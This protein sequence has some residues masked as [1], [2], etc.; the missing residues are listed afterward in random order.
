MSWQKY[1]QLETISL[2]DPLTGLSNRRYLQKV[3]T[4]DIAK[5]ER[6]I[7]DAQHNRQ[8]RKLS[9]DMTFFLLDVDFFKSV[10]DIYGHMAGDQVLIQLSALLSKICRQTDCLVR[11]GGEEFLI[12]SRF[13]SREE[14]PLM[15]ERIRKAV[16]AHEFML[17]DGTVLRKTCSM[18]FACYPFLDG[19]PSELSWEH[20]VDVADRALYVAKRSGRN[21]TV[22]IMASATTPHENLY[23]KIQYN[24]KEMITMGDL[25][26]VVQTDDP[27]NWD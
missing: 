26:A 12:V 17:P 8:P 5:V 1:A 10:N 15:A 14:A 16:A 19:K 25:I 2:S 13:A 11:W 20:V 21:R 18:G 7:S 27:L 4:M 23:E 9:L 24:L 3:I 6:E 22:G